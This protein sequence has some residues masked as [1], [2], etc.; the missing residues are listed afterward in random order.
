MG[1]KLLLQERGGG[2]HGEKEIMHAI[3]R[4]RGQTTAEHADAE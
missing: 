1:G 2:R 3:W 4:L